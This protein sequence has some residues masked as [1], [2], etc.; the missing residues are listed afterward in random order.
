MALV[1]FIS[2]EVKNARVRETD[3]RKRGHHTE[4]ENGVGLQHNH[5]PPWVWIWIVGE[6]CGEED[7]DCF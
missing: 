3:A 4:D 5:E 2:V 1:E 6:E 7:S